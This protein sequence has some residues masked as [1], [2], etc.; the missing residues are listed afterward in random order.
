MLSLRSLLWRFTAA[1]K[2]QW[3]KFLP[4]RLAPRRGAPLPAQLD[5]KLL[6][7]LGERRFPGWRQLKYLRHFLKPWEARA[8]LLSGLAVAGGLILGG[9]MFLRTHLITVPKRG[10]EY[11]EAMVGQ[12][13]L[14][15]P[16]Y[17]AANEVDADLAA[18]IYNGLYT[19]AGGELQPDLA[20]G[21]NISSD[22]KTYEIRLKTD[23]R[24]S[25]GEPFTADDVVFTWE[26]INHPE[27][28]SPLRLAFAGVKVEKIDDYRVRFVTPELLAPF[29]SSL[30]VGILPEHVWGGIPP[31]NFKLAKSN[32]QPVG[33]GR[34]QFSKLTKDDTGRI[35]SYTLA[36]NPA[37]WRATPPPY[38]EQLT[39]KFY[40]EVD[41]AQE[42]QQNHGADAVSFYPLLTGRQSR[43]LRRYPLALPEY[44]ALFFNPAAE[45]ALKSAATRQAL[46]QAIDKLALV[47][48]V[49]AGYGEPSDAPLL[50]RHLGYHQ[51]IKRYPFAPEESNRLLDTAWR[52]LDPSEYFAWETAALLK[53]I[54]TGTAATSTPGAAPPAVPEAVAKSVRARMPA[55]QLWYRANKE[56]RTFNLTITTLNLPEYA[57]VAE[58]IA[59]AWRA[60]GINTDVK[61]ADG[62]EFAR[63]V[64]RE[65]D[66]QV[67]LYGE[68]VGLDPDLFA[69][70]HSSQINYPGLNLSG[71]GT[72]A[73]DQLLED[74]RRA[75][76]T[77]RR[78]VIYQ[79]FQDELARE[80]PA[81]FLYH[82]VHLL[83]I[84]EAI[85]GVEIPLLSVPADRYAKIAQWYRKTKWRLK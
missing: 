47:R 60:A 70:W 26:M 71:F 12:P 48:D 16:L 76:S 45:A 51:E 50:P 15:N 74:G 38:L 44:V 28:G 20:A 7:M 58:A 5:R 54:A 56:K 73:T 62:R 13:K 14:I 33:T 24:W 31:A 49:L 77:A 52:R 78:A 46:A 2:R 72:R 22:G 27:T 11:S 43:A 63:S 61:L 41:Q 37:E 80:L 67:L 75:T 35:Q 30:T 29:L 82:P 53:P 66:Y 3:Q 55:D 59:K 39:F 81:I 79:K 85:K 10:G 69:F 68:V 4:A 18:L 57:A 36:P 17:A 32:L 40:P 9:G 42:A 34:W 8:L 65:R 19:T 83:V 84:D 6:A 64:L 25:D 1:L 21:V 23:V